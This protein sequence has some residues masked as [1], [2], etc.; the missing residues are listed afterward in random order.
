MIS[1]GILKFTFKRFYKDY[2][3]MAFYLISMILFLFIFALDQPLL[4]L[5]PIELWVYKRTF[6]FNI[7]ISLV[8]SAGILGKEISDGF[9]VMILS[10]P[11]RRSSVYFSKFLSSLL[12]CSCLLMLFLFCV[13]I[14]ITFLH[15]I[16]FSYFLLLK[17]FFL[18]SIDQV[19]IISLSTFL[20]VLLPREMNI[21]F[22]IFIGILV[23][24]FPY[25]FVSSGLPDYTIHIFSFLNPIK[26]PFMSEEFFLKHSFPFRYFLAFIAYT[27]MLFT[28]GILIFH[29][30]EIK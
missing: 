23:F 10:K 21:L 24:L 18:L 19:A 4:Q 16:S 7:V 12:Y 29:R 1:K 27:I 6:F 5:E 2:S 8:L 11:I 28:A 3:I 9:M 20:S 25:I 13:A 22:L 15:K 14:I 30:R 17:V 26:S